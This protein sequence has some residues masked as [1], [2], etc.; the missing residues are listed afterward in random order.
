MTTFEPAR[1]P[2]FPTRWSERPATAWALLAVALPVGGWLLWEI[3]RT[4]GLN[5]PRFWELLRTDRVFDVAMLDFCLTAGWAGLVLFERA[6]RRDWRT[7]AALALFCVIPSLG[8][9]AFILVRS[10][11]E[12]AQ[13]LADAGSINA[14]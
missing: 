5:A 1:L 4:I 2:I 9:A 13:N 12:P 14:R 3:H 8:I 10:R 7:W 11:P 6:S